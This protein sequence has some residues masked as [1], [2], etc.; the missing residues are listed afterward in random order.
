MLCNRRWSDELAAILLGKVL[1]GHLASFV[2]ADGDVFIVSVD[3]QKQAVS[4][5]LWR[6]LPEQQVQEK[7]RVHHFD[8][9]RRHRG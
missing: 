6:G 1:D 7:D 4:R 2:R 8:D 5:D 9:H 3:G